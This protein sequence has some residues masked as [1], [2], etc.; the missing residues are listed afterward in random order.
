MTFCSA[1]LALPAP[2]ACG[3]P[4]DTAEGA[5]LAERG[6]VDN[7]WS[8]NGNGEERALFIMQVQTPYCATGFYTYLPAG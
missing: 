5:G 4:L 3:R 8:Q 7:V 6:G 2:H 1:A